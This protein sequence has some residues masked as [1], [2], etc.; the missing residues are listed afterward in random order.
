MA[1]TYD[2]TAIF[3]STSASRIRFLI[4]D[5]DERRMLLDDDELS[6][7]ITQYTTADAAA[8]PAIRAAIKKARH[9]VNWSS[10]SEREDASQRLPQLEATLADLIK[11]G[12]TDPT[13]AT[14]GLRVAQFVRPVQGNTTNSE[15]A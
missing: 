11:E 14:G 7:M 3:T 13:G 15:F 8:V 9:Q 12:F 4:G 5:T 2:G 10:G 6:A 1:F